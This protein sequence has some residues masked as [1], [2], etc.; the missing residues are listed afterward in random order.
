[1]SETVYIYGLYDP[2]GGE[3]RYVGKTI[4]LQ[5]RLWDHVTRAKS[6]EGNGKSE[7][8]SELLSLN[9]QPEVKIL[10]ETDEAGWEEAEKRWI[11]DSLDEGLD[12]LNV[13]EG[14]GS[15][16]D[17]AGRKQSKEHIRKRV[18]ARRRNNTY[19]QSE[20]TKR[21]ISQAKQGTKTGENN[22]FYGREHSKATRLKI[23]KANRGHKAWNKGIPCSEETKLK[24]SR[25]KKGQTLS[26]EARKKLSES[27]KG[28]KLSPEHIEK[29]RQANLGRRLSEETKQKLREANLGKTHSEETKE[30]LREIFTGRFVSEDTREKLRKAKTGWKMTPEQ[31]AERSEDQKKK[32]QDPEYRVK[33][34]E[35]Q[36][37]RRERERLEKL[38]A[39]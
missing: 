34:L 39:E 30:K 22:P 20:K 37:K 4:N 19:T 32:W 27:L 1:V 18:E 3:L 7:W 23:S 24:V 16:P 33:M 6:G 25:S 29:I 11:A 17:W 8:I 38:A 35:A 10:E 5:A 26:R 21:K 13:S 12:L 15:P 31:K 2:R 14:G 9:L 36:R 28:R